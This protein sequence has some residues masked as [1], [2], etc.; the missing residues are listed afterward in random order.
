MEGKDVNMISKRYY[1]Y[2]KFCSGSIYSNLG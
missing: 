1:I 2:F